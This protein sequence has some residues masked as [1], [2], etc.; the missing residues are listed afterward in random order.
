MQDFMLWFIVTIVV[1]FTDFFFSSTWDCCLKLHCAVS[2][3]NFNCWWL[4]FSKSITL[5]LSENRQRP[6]FEISIALS[7]Y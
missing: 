2:F 7:R 3:H 6:T 1:N 5:W 4:Y